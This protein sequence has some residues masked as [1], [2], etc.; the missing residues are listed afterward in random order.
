[1]GAA[2][3]GMPGWPELAFSTASAASRRMVF[4]H[5]SSKLVVFI[6]PPPILSSQISMAAYLF[7]SF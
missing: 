6:G 2:P 5:S 4:T 3:M 7:I 1:M